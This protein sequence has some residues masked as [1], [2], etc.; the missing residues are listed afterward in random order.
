MQFLQQEPGELLRL[1][2]CWPCSA[3]CLGF[4]AHSNLKP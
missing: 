2:C 4:S 3:V 1:A